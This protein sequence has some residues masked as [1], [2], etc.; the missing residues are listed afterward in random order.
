MFVDLIFRWFFCVFVVFEEVVGFGDEC[1]F[2]FRS[3]DVDS[4]RGVS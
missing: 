1:D 4:F 3:F 2:G